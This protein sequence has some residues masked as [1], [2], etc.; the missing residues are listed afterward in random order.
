MMLTRLLRSAAQAIG[1]GDGRVENAEG[2][3]EMAQRRVGKVELL[4]DR[5]GEDADDVPVDEIEDVGEEKKQEHARPD[6]A[7]SLIFDWLFRQNLAPNDRKIW[8]G[9]P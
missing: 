9:L 5:H 3:A 8:R 1:N 6:C 2:D 4:A 7:R